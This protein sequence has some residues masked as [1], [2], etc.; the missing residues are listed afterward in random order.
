MSSILGWVTAVIAIVS[1]SQPRPAV[2]HKTSI[3]RIALPAAP[4]LAFSAPG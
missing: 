2:I 1:P 3:S 4:A